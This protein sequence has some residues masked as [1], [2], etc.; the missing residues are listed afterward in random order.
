MGSFIE[1]PHE[2]DIKQMIKARFDVDID[3]DG[4]WGYT[5]DKATVI[6]TKQPPL[7]QLEHNLAMMR[8]YIEMNMTLTSK[9]RYG[10]I[11]VSQTDSETIEEDGFVF[12]K[13]TN[14]ITAIKEEKYNAFIKEYKENYEKDSFDLAEHFERRK[15]E[16]LTRVVEHWFEVSQVL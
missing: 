6:K 7:K 12:H 8:A 2:E 1:I 5:Q 4:S 16:T 14:T 9:K 10:G 3:V 11:N 15:K 13:V